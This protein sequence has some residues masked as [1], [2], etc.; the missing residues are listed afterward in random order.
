MKKFSTSFSLEASHLYIDKFLFDL[1]FLIKLFK[2]FSLLSQMN[3]FA[4][5][6]K[7][8]FNVASPIP[9]AAAD[10]IIFLFFK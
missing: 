2:K 4:P 5:L 3:N 9:E 1:Y 10:I 8:T 6:D 7:Q